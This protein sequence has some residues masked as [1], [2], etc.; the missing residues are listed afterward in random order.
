[1]TDL[2]DDL[3]DD[4]PDHVSDAATD[5]AR[6]LV[7]A[8]AD[9][10]E[11]PVP[12]ADGRAVHWVDIFAGEVHTTELAG[13]ATTTVTVDTLVGAVATRTREPG[14]VAA[15]REGFATIGPDGLLSTRV[16]LLPQGH[17]M[18]DAACDS[19]GRFWAGSTTM[20]FAPG[21]GALHVL[22]PDWTTRCVLHG[23]TLPNGLGWSPDDATFYLVDSGRR[24]LT[25][26]DVDRS[27][28]DLSN[29]RVL[30]R[31][32]A[33]EGIPDGL[34]VDASG[35]VWVAMWGGG[36]LLR[37][38]PDGAVQDRVELP[39][40]QPSSCA[41]VGPDR[42]V[43]VVTSATQD[44]RPA[45]DDDGLDGSLLVVPGVHARGLP[46]HEFTG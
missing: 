43:M 33:G 22:L 46:T 7:R 12:S 45:A 4:V 17:R 37:L 34:C 42:D 2:T 39:V 14:W 27:R 10:G 26:F 25:A 24:V 35:D 20:D 28:G 44:L 5:A 1:V 23:L 36:S 40:R 8:R 32:T 19:S 29:E 15:T 6:V 11:G 41:L 9:V 30:R 38:S 18:N 16:R 31:F 13:G 21:E 3:I